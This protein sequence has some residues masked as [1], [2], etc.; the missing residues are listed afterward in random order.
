MVA[1]LLSIPI[2]AAGIWLASEADNE[3]VKLLQWPVIII[4][5]LVL[6]VALAGFVGAFWRIPWLLLF[7]LAAMLILIILLAILV[8]FAYTVTNRG[9]GHPVPGRRYLE[10][11]LDDYS[12]WMRRRVQGSFK[13]HRIQNCLRSTS[14]CSQMNQTYPSPEVFF[15]APISPLQ[16][17]FTTTFILHSYSYVQKFFFLYE[18]L[19]AVGFCC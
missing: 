13:W 11:H 7:Y 19:R 15:N 5:I 16:V 3:C 17:I 2:I 12:V 9:Y 4:G 18:Y 14:I 8:V 6:V 1:M 10:Y